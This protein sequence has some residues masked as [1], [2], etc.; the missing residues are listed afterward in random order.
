VGGILKIHT[1]FRLR[2][3]QRNPA[4][5]GNNGGRTNS[6]SQPHPCCD[7]RESTTLWWHNPSYI[8]ANL[9]TSPLYRSPPLAAQCGTFPGAALLRP[10][11]GLLARIPG[12]N[13]GRNTLMGRNFVSCGFLPLELPAIHAFRNFQRPVSGGDLQYLNTRT[14][15]PPEP[16]SGAGIFDPPW[17]FTTNGSWTRLGHAS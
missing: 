11:P 14:F 6:V 8:N 17:Q 16:L 15:L 5:L 7:P 2:H 13:A 1:A 9:Y 10:A 4:G 3:L 12:A